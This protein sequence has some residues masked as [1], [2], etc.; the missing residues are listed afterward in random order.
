MA[1][2]TTY[3]LKDYKKEDGEYPVYCRLYINRQKVN[4]PVKIHV[5]E[6]SWDLE[7]QRVK[8]IS[9]EAKD[10]NLIISKIKSRINDVF[11]SF[12]LN[13]RTLTRD[14]FL[15][16]FGSV[17]T[18]ASFWHFMD[19]QLQKRKG[20]IAT[21]TYRAHQ[22]TLKKFREILPNLQFY[23]FTD[24]TI[25][26]IK[27]LL[28]KQYS[29]N[30]N[31]IAKN[32]IT[33]KTYVGFAMRKKLLDT[34][35]FSVEKIKRVKPT[36]VWL[37]EGELAKFIEIY[38][39]RTLQDNYHR[40]L[41]YF[42][43]ACFTGFRLSD[44]KS[45]SMDQVKGDFLMINPIKTKRVNNEIVTIPLTQPIKRILRD[46]APF[47][48]EGLV[49]KCF[50]DP[51]TNRML[52]KI[53]EKAGVNKDITFHSARHTFATFF[54]EKTDDL[55]TLQKLLGHSDITQTMVYVHLTE[56][57]KVEQMRRCWNDIKL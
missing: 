43:F 25:R 35:P 8:G 23:E 12:R 31:T 9:K 18:Y 40:V 27:K 50:A 14:I 41:Q 52:K 48:L 42:L 3:L 1:T 37:T 20:T 19:D 39:D 28:G 53:A 2:V 16:E 11:V 54:L 4:I 10:A 22:S 21:N 13:N 34:N 26:D 47:R 6:N 57:K 45:F 24:E 44:V 5:N 46:V 36:Q 17:S 30:P 7:N 15:K 38:R 56:G 51:V 55:A 33:L 32:L 49:F 29:N